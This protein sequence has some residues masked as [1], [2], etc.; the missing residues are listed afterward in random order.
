MKKEIKYFF[1]LVTCV[2]L[3]SCSISDTENIK[4]PPQSVDEDKEESFYV[5]EK[6]RTRLLENNDMVL[7]YSGGAHRDYIWD[8]SLIEPYVIYKDKSGKEQW[9]F[10]SFLFLEIH[11]GNGKSF[12]T[13]Y[14]PVPANQ[15]EWKKLVDHYFQ[16]KYCLG[17]LNRSIENA[18]KRIGEPNEKRKVVIGIPEPIKTQKDWG[19]VSNGVMLDF[20]KSSDRIAACKWYIDYTRQKFSELNYKNLELSG[21]YWIAEE[22]TNTRDIL[23]E[24][25]SYLNNLKYSFIWIPYNGSDG[26]FEWKQ[27]NFNYAYYQPN[28]FFNEDRPISIL[29]KACEDAVNY[30]MDMEIEFDD[31]ALVGYGNWGYRLENYMN[32]F[33]EYGIWKNSR[34]AYYQGG[35]T[36]YKLSKATDYKDDLLYHKFCKFVTERPK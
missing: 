33:K 26:A 32:S 31:R 10:D 7:L 12:A 1:L 2:I 22:A 34:I 20:S 24:L 23:S 9:M 13:G 4:P 11:N 35:S 28:Y 15:Q 30:R 17:A 5:R 14:T 27:L 36:L 8:E 16:S 29:N 18:K 6:N 25:S 3:T 21:F 19:S